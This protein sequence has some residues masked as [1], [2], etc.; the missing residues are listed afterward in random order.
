M[1]KAAEIMGGSAGRKGDEWKGG[2]PRRDRAKQAFD[3]I[4]Q[5]A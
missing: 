3:A 5:S 4:R 1:Q 2:G